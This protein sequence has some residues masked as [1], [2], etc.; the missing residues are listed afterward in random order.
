M[1]KNIKVVHSITPLIN[2]NSKILI[3]GSFPS[4]KS[5][6]QQFF[7][8]HPQNRFWK[9]L[10]ILFNDDFTSCTIEEK[11]RLCI[12]NNIAIYD[13][14]NSCTIVGSSDSS[15][16]NVIPNNIKELIQNT[17]ITNIFC[18]GNK[19]YELFLK[20]NKDIDISVHL[21][22]SSSPAN[23]R[24][25]LD[26]LVKSWSIIKKIWYLNYFVVKFY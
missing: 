16:E 12:K 6:E 13:V 5:R 9:I 22:P 21:L 3:L 17:K 24:M 14:I 7:Y 2:S 20:Y 18:N 19:A 25:K 4:V 1:E 8:M 26:D 15:I 23:A 11:K 10:S